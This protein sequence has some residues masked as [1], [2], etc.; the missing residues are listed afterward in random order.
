MAS[1]EDEFC[2]SRF[3]KII[4]QGANYSPTHVLADGAFSITNAVSS[5]F[6]E[7]V[8]LMCWAHAIK[9]IDKQLN[10]MEPATKRDIRRDIQDLQYALN[11]EQFRK[12]NFWAL[13]LFYSFLAADL[14]MQNW[15]TN[16]GEDFAF[17]AYFRDTWINSP[18]WR[19][20]EGK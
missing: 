15:E 14:L 10:R 1:N 4:A 5:A 9:N 2:F 6:P 20:F 13:S 16:Y 17:V 18:H 19:W 11:E 3:F 12:G 7:A 8:R